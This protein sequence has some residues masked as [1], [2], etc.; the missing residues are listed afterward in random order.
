MS[1]DDE[2]CNEIAD[3]RILIAVLWTVR[4]LNKISL[5]NVN[6]IVFD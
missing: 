2:A 1:V 6:W 3:E 5:C 4:I